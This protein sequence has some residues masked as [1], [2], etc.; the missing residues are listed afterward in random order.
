MAIK[1]K[2]L[3]KKI[4]CLSLLI[5]SLT[6]IFFAGYF[7]TDK[8]LESIA[9]YATQVIEENT[10]SK[11]YCAV[12]VSS[13]SKSGSIADPYSEFHNLYGI[14]NERRVTFASAINTYSQS[15]KGKEHDIFIKKN[16]ASLSDNLSLFY[17]G[18]IGSIDYNNHHKHYVYPLET[19]FSDQREK[20]D[21]LPTKFVAY[22]SQT[23]ADRLLET[24]GEVRDKDGNY[25]IEQY[26]TLLDNEE[27]NIVNVQFDEEI[28]D[29]A[30]LNIYYQS[31]YYYEGVSEILGDFIAISYYAPGDL[32]KEQKNIYFLNTYSYQNRYFM[33]YINGVYENGKFDVSVNLY[34]II[35]KVNAD[36]LTS[37]YNKSL[38]NQTQWLAVLLVILSAAL[39]I[40]VFYIVIKH[41][42]KLQPFI[43]FGCFLCCLFPYVLFKTISKLSYSVSFFTYFSCVAYFIFISIVLVFVIAYNY[44]SRRNFVFFK[45]V[46]SGDLNEINI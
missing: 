18:P 45:R 11:Q 12:N 13:N 29:Y 44:S 28:H 6:N 36:Y 30:I 21:V 14:F 27:R 16:G 31:N 39:L 25:S 2:L 15:K 7:S 5:A 24:F 35:G 4:L 38:T 9:T 22:I 17:L 23:H 34:N 26:R 32:R 10:K 40:V 42:I 1:N 41:R 46:H 20:Y 8:S 3:F 43:L 33:Q 19:I 37:F